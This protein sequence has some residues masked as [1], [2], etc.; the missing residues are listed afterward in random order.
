VEESAPPQLAQASP[1][2][3]PR[4]RDDGSRVREETL[5]TGTLT[6]GKSAATYSLR[7]IVHIGDSGTLHCFRCHSEC[8]LTL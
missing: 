3:Y 2:A 7:W 1:S 6:I 4:P 8:P 5:S